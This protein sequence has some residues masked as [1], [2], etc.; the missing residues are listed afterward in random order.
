MFS[1]SFLYSSGVSSPEREREGNPF[2]IL[3]ALARPVVTGLGK[4]IILTPPLE[5]GRK[6]KPGSQEKKGENDVDDDIVVTAGGAKL[7]EIF[8]AQ[9]T[10]LRLPR[11]IW[12]IKKEKLFR[13]CF[14]SI[15]RSIGTEKRSRTKSI[16]FLFRLFLGRTMAAL[17]EK[18]SRQEIGAHLFP[19]FLPS[20]WKS[21]DNT[22]HAF[23]K[24]TN[25]L[26][27]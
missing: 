25:S 13:F 19:S 3:L 5:V 24:A 21:N 18:Q 2:D 9:P 8:T 20:S 23:R 26:W 16:L 14:G 22:R 12:G 4:L 27:K 17:A 11:I 15:D 10:L 6:C 1:L 7:R